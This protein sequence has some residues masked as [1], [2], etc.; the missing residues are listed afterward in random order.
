MKKN[1]DG[2]SLEE[3]A[4]R[5]PS[6]TREMVMQAMQ[7]VPLCD[8]GN[9]A[10]VDQKKSVRFVICSQTPFST[11]LTKLSCCPAEASVVSL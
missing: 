11:D 4:R 7:R 10:S 9:N 1:E 5:P 8:N 3:R 2:D 6:N